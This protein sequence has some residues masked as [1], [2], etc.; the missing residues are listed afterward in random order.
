M[1]AQYWLISTDH[2]FDRLWFRDDEDYSA[3]MNLVAVASFRTGIKILSFILMSNH[4]HFVVMGD[5][6][7]AD[8]FI[9]GLKNLYSRYY[10]EKYCVKEFLRDNP[11]D[12]R[13]IHPNGEELER[14]IAYVQMNCVAANICL[15]PTLYPWGTGRSFFNT[16]ISKEQSSQMV[17]GAFSRTRQKKMLHSH[18]LLPQNFCIS[19]GYI[20][21][22][23]YVDCRQV[24][25][26]FKTPGRMQFFLFNSSK[27][28]IR[29][30]DTEPALPSFRD[31]S[32][33]AVIP[34]LCRSLFRKEAVQ[35]LSE[36]QK[37][38]FFKQLRRRLGADVA[39]MARVTGITPT[40]VSNYLDQF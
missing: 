2:L 17:L 13:P 36:T 37:A 39:Q 16:H 34:D 29:L 7:K 28:K 10:R 40:E 26:I 31:Q 22:E 5:R 19:N 6:D 32:L 38:E 25:R 12:I 14:A 18:M 11:V 27:A 3:A 1:A 33:L 20:D 35:E 15:H 4:L 30:L 21:P 9:T 24:E 23:S 8:A